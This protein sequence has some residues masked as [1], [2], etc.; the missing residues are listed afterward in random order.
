M[1]D[2]I[3]VDIVADDLTRVID[4]NRPRSSTA[5]KI[6]RLKVAGGHRRTRKEKAVLHPIQHICPHNRSSIIER[7]GF[8][9]GAARKIDSSKSPV[10]VA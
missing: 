5:G 6:N 4:P 10:A 8:G 7:K 1:S 9:L 2:A 3:S